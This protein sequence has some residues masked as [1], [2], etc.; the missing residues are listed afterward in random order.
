[1]QGPPTEQGLAHSLQNAIK[2]TLLFGFFPI[3][4]LLNLDQ[5]QEIISVLLA[6]YQLLAL[7]LSLEKCQTQCVFFS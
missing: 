2:D 3:L 5:D 1:M 4:T 6:S 7:Y